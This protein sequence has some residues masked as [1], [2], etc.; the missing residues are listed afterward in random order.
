[1]Y[2]IRSYYGY[3]VRLL[4]VNLKKNLSNH[5]LKEKNTIFANTFY[6]LKRVI[7]FLLQRVQ[8]GLSDLKYRL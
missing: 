2:A 8:K 5:I 1:M 3:K 6:K 4:N 7:L